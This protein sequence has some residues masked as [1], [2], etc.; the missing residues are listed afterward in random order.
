MDAYAINGQTATVKGFSGV[1]YR[2]TALLAG[3]AAGTFL[4]ES[5]AAIGGF[6]FRCQC[7]YPH[8]GT[9]STDGMA[10]FDSRWTGGGSN[11][12]HPNFNVAR[13]IEVE[14]IKRE[15]ARVLRWASMNGEQVTTAHRAHVAKLAK[16]RHAEAKAF[17]RTYGDHGA[18]LL[19]MLSD[20]EAIDLAVTALRSPEASPERKAWERAMRAAKELYFL[21]I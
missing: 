2:A 12:V 10:D 14:R 18:A 4:T 5:A 21:T 8:E 7:S 13:M 17:V 11:V 19:A 6:Q 9:C 1:F 15:T 3:F 16:G 20:R